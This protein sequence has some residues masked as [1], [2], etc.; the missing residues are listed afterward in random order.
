MKAICSIRTARSDKNKNPFLVLRKTES[1]VER[2]VR[3]GRCVTV[4]N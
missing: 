3:G 1:I 2:A 4:I